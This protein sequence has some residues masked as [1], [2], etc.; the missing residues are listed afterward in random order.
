VY[1]AVQT[2]HGQDVVIKDGTHDRHHVMHYRTPSAAE[3]QAHLSTRHRGPGSLDRPH[4]ETLGPTNYP[5]ATIPSRPLDRKP[6]E[7]CLRL[8]RACPEWLDA[9]EQQAHLLRGQR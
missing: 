7:E 9:A 1:D 4:G 8:P 3:H 6:T 2:A 5:T